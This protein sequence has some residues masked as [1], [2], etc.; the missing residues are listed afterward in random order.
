MKFLL[1]Q[2]IGD[3]VWALHKVQS[4]ACRHMENRIDIYLACND[5]NEVATRALDF[6]R[7]FSF[8]DSVEMRPY[9]I[10]PQGDHYDPSGYYNY[11]PDGM[12]DFDGE[13]CCAL[14][15][16]AALERGT[17]LEA[18]L[19]QYAINWKIFD[20]FKIAEL[21]K[22][23][24]NSIRDRMGCPYV[25]FYLGPLH[26]NTINGHNRNALW[27]PEDWIALGRRIHNEWGANIVLVGA[28]YDASYYDRLIGPQLNGDTPYWFNLIGQTNIG[29]LFTITSGA[30]FVISYQAGVGI[31]S[32]Y[33]GTPTGIFWRPRGDSISPDV[34]LSFEESMA[35]AWVP[36]TQIANGAHMPLIYGRDGVDHI[37]NE[38]RTRGWV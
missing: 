34:Y 7:R 26:G 16:N 28:S 32:T 36:P 8:V 5:Q 22:A 23:L 35:S 21:E 20:N 14:M 10:H 19:P 25:V 17:R 1:P 38:I 24:A 37:M 3:S 31:V 29:E 12:Y 4:V 6:V 18:W 11:L 2:G 27:R 13:R 30:Q 15:P 9:E 33:L